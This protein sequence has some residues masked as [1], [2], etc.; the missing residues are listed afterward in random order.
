MKPT[1]KVY[2]TIFTIHSWLGLVNGFWLLI[3]GLTGSL[4]VYTEELD[5]WINRDVL[6]AAP[7]E[8]RLTYDSL[9]RIVRHQFP[10]AM[11]ANVIRFPRKADESVGFRVYV[12]DGSKPMKDWSQMYFIDLDPYSGRILRKGNYASVGDSFLF[13]S[14]S[15]HWSLN[16]GQV[17]ILIITLAGILLFANIL[18][19][20]IVYRKYFFKAMIFRAPV[21]WRNWRTGTSGL[22]RYVGVWA[23]VLN[24]L[25]FYSGLQMTWSVFSKE[26]WQHPVAGTPNSGPYASID[27]MMDETQRVFPGFEMKYFYIPFTKVVIDGVD[28]GSASAMGRIP[29]TPAIIPLSRSTVTFDIH[30]GAVIE[31]VN[32]NERL[33]AL[34]WW[35]K[36]NFVAYSF[37][38]GTFAGEFSRVLYVIIGLTPA[39]LAFSGFM[40]WWRRKRFFRSA[41]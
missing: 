21:H 20:I 6:R 9:S 27:M 10:L 1:R 31:K 28:L 35:E 39:L 14:S 5:E 38:A 8:T 23:L 41:K 7:A 40:L 33:A 13:W 2:Q 4:F 12:E 24:I 34:N 29:G 16:Y 3:L 18:T 15:F 19:G 25:I 22:H 26:G 30:T 11:G 36:F 17:G 37:H 32:A